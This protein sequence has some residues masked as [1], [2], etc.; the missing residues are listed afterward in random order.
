MPAELLHGGPRGD[1]SPGKEVLCYGSID[2]LPDLIG[3]CLWDEEMT[4]AVASSGR[5]RVTG[6]ATT[7]CGQISLVSYPGGFMRP[8]LILIEPSFHFTTMSFNPNS[9]LQRRLPEAKISYEIRSRRSGSRSIPQIVGVISRADMI[10]AL[11]ITEPGGPAS[12]ALRFDPSV[13]KVGCY[14]MSHWS[15]NPDYAL[16]PELSVAFD[17]VYV[18]EGVSRS[19]TG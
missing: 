13:R 17:R 11:S 19:G 6:L 18:H 10:L 3:R 16:I 8:S 14:L 5:D 12:V 2:E 4:R 9:P 15:L 1:S 7:G